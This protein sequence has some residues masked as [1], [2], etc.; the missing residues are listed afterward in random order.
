MVYCVGWFLFPCS[1]RCHSTK[2][3]PFIEPWFDWKIHGHKESE[4]SICLVCWWSL[5]KSKLLPNWSTENLFMNNK[6][7][8][9]SLNVI[10]AHIELILCLQLTAAVACLHHASLESGTVYHTCLPINTS[11]LLN[12]QDVCQHVW[13]SLVEI[14]CVNHSLSQGG[15]HVLV[16]WVTW[17]S[18]RLSV[19]T[20]QLWMHS[21]L[22]VVHCRHEASNKCTELAC[23][24]DA[25]VVS[26]QR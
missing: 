1:P 4:V 9:W 3:N 14:E 16:T 8:Y 23:L 5:E 25:N 15:A 20:C 6:Y 19:N 10:K 7:P 21:C 11:L 12:K 13:W 2:Q 22:K 24:S 17:V 26:I 18:H